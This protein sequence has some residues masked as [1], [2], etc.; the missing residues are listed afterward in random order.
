[1]SSK[2]NKNNIFKPIFIFGVSRSGTTVFYNMFAH[3]PDLAFISN[4]N[5]KFPKTPY[6]WH[7]NSLFGKAGL[8]ARLVKPDEA[9]PLFNSIFPGYANPIRNLRSHDV[10][11]EVCEGIRNLVNRNLIIQGKRRFVYKYTGWPRI[12]FFNAIFQDALFIHIIR[13]GRAVANSKLSVPWWYGWRGP[14]NWRWGELPE[15]YREEWEEGNRSFAL[16]AGI[17][18]KMLLDEVERSREAISENRL[19]AL[20]TISIVLGVS[21]D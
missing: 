7:I 2:E 5:V 9:Y 15:E 10:S 12:G 21:Q 18:W 1:M 14:Q 16:L 8:R 3:H 11:K 13:D 17:E 4:F 19:W 6:I 20:P